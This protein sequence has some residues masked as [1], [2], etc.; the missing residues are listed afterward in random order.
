MPAPIEL[1]NHSQQRWFFD[2]DL[3][4]KA[5]AADKAGRTPKKVKTIAFA[6]KDND[7]SKQRLSAE[8]FALLCEQYGDVLA[9]HIKRERFALYGAELPK[10]AA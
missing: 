1:I 5:R 4:A 9:D 8:D 6:A 2:L 10:A 7:G 3:N